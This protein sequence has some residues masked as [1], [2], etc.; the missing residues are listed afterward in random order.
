MTENKKECLHINWEIPEGSIIKCL[1]CGI[2]KK[3]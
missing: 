3:K 2:E 1:D